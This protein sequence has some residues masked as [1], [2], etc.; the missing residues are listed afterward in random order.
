V[1][2]Q[3]KHLKL[4]IL[5]KQNRRNQSLCSVESFNSNKDILRLKRTRTMKSTN[6]C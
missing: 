5:S 6:N 3:G 4:K 2:Q 1:D